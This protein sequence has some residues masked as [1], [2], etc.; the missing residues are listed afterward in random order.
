MN[1]KIHPFK[2]IQIVEDICRMMAVEPLEESFEWIYSMEVKSD[3]RDAII[4]NLRMVISQ[5]PEF[6]VA[7]L[8]QL[9]ILQM[10]D[11]VHTQK[12]IYWDSRGN[13]DRVV[14]L[15]YRDSFLFMADMDDYL[16]DNF[17]IFSPE[18]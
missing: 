4:Y 15:A 17:G 6:A 13:M 2:P 14:Y 3:E 8:S 5:L 9:C 11:S 1:S 10:I 7:P 18:L 12:D 16:L